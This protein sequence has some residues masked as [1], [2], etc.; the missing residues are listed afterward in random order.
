MLSFVFF[1]QELSFG[2]HIFDVFR[3]E[4]L[5][6]GANANHEKRHSIAKESCDVP[7]LTALDDED[8]PADFAQVLMTDQS[9]AKG[10]PFPVFLGTP[11]F[12]QIVPSVPR[13]FFSLAN[14]HGGWMGRS[15][16]T[17]TSRAA[18]RLGD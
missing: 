17:R 8:V 9:G 14:C 13:E 12:G 3:N 15:T 10:G 7:P 6:L 2:T 18:Q 4:A 11:I 1:F 5:N 16:P